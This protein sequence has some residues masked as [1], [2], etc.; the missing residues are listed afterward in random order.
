MA[1]N[2]DQVR[3]IL[4][5][6]CSHPDHVDNIELEIFGFNG[7]FFCSDMYK[8]QVTLKKTRVRKDLLIKTLPSNDEAMSEYNLIEQFNIE[9]TMYAECIPEIFHQEIDLFAD[10]YYLAENIFI[11]DDLSAEGFQMG[12][13]HALDR[14]HFE[15]ALK[16]LGRLHAASLEFKVRNSKRFQEISDKLFKIDILE[17]QQMGSKIM[18][19]DAI[20]LFKEKY[21][22]KA[23][24]PGLEN[25][26]NSFMKNYTDHRKFVWQGEE[27]W[28]VLCHGDFNR[29]N[30]LFKYDEGGNPVAVKFFDLQTSRVTSPVIDLSFFIYL[31][32]TLELRKQT[33][34]LQLYFSPIESKMRN[35]NLESDYNFKSFQQEYAAR[36]FYGFLICMDF[37]RMIHTDK[38]E[39]KDIKY[40]TSNI[41][42]WEYIKTIGGKEADN[43]IAEMVAEFLDKNYYPVD[44]NYN[45]QYQSSNNKI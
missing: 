19:L 21:P 14:A 4:A 15:L 1:L 13:K 24:H 40:D 5:E 16:G 38:E 29:N 41:E 31:N 2:K 34:L 32:S 22:E 36:A 3:A 18:G 28:R 17:I 11:F 37:L 30:M 8:A 25:L 33:D 43:R 6:K 39:L 12:P 20:R 45:K 27:P 9:R 26:A 7:D 10:A 35:L 44:L 42:L 23:D